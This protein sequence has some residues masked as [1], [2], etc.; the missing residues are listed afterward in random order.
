M[1]LNRIENNLLHIVNIDVVDK[2]PLLD[3]KPYV[4]AFDVQDDV[5]SGWLEEAEDNVA[6]YFSDDRFS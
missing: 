4:P 6:E 2:T 1:K 5:R 3:I